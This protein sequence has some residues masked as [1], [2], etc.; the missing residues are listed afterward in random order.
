M[1]A[2]KNFYDSSIWNYVF[3]VCA[4]LLQRKGGEIWY[5]LQNNSEYIKEKNPKIAKQV[6]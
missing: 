1:P 2:F 5:V 6:K 3:G 4:G